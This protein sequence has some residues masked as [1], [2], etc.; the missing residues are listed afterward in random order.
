M[1]IEHVAF[2]HPEPSVAA[3]WY[4]DHFGLRV[5]RADD[6]PSRTRFLTDS[7]GRT[8]IEI[9]D[10]RE[11][12]MPD[13]FIQSPVLLHFAFKSD[14][15]EADIKRF[16]GVG[17]TVDVF[18]KTMPNGDVMAFMRDL[19]GVPFQLVKR[20]VPLGEGPGEQPLAA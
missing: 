9:Y 11:E 18:P 7:T 6:G 3:S 13:Y 10:N 19:W 8:V 1:V 2:Q 16:I 15:V 12:T 14:D 20:A 17:A 4:S 5:V